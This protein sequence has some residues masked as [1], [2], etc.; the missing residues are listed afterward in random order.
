[1]NYRRDVVELTWPTFFDGY[2]VQAATRVGP[3]ADWTAHE[4]YKHIHGGAFEVSLPASAGYRYFRLI[5][6]PNAPL[7]NNNPN[8]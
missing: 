7:P 4:H 6:P 2:V 8:N 1:M 5:Q 3:D